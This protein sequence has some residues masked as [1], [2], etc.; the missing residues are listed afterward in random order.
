MRYIDADALADT[1]YERYCEDCD[2]RKGMKN[3]KMRTIYAVGDAP[4]RACGIDDMIGELE[5]APTAQPEPQWIPCGERLP[6]HFDWY[7]VSN[8]ETSWI[9]L[10]KDGVFLSVSGCFEFNDIIAWMPL[11]TPYQENSDA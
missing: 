6:E 11:P 3:G 9:A 5:D 2:K 1:L 10:W 7:L 8:K 4:C